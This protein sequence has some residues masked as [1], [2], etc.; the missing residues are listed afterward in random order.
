MNQPEINTDVMPT[1]KE[2]I[3]SALDDIGVLLD[4]FKVNHPT[5]FKAKE[6]L[7]FLRGLFK[8]ELHD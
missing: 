8:E 7:Y 5:V 1:R 6:G 4:T 2:L 3:N